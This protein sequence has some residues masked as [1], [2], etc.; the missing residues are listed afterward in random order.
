[1]TNNRNLSELSTQELDQ[2]IKDAEKEKVTKSVKEKVEAY[3]QLLEIAKNINLPLADLILF[4]EQN[5]KK[6]KITKKA[7]PRYRNKANPE[8]TWTG[9]GKKPRWL[10]AEIEN[11]AILSDF[12]I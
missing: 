5:S 2:L 7:E 12:L 9:R 6:T 3:E 4:G 1:M 10:S 11:G 8:E